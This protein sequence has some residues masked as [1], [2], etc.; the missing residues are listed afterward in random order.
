[1][2]SSLKTARVSFFGTNVVDA[3]PSASH[4]LRVY[5]KALTEGVTTLTKEEKEVLLWFMDKCAGAVCDKWRKPLVKRGEAYSTVVTTADEALALQIMT[6]YYRKEGE[7]DQDYTTICAAFNNRDVAKDVAD[8]DST[9]SDSGASTTPKK[10]RV[11]GQAVDMAI[12]Y[13]NK[14]V[15][16]LTAIKNIED[17]KI[18]IATLDNFIMRMYNNGGSSFGDDNNRLTRIARKQTNESDA[19]E[20]AFPAF[21]LTPV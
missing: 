17:N 8:C 11:S 9:G 16:Q 19:L 7:I 10:K 20:V 4:L 3:I 5:I 21:P 15:M 18:R 6:F 2:N 12:R 1:M 14:K 13:Y